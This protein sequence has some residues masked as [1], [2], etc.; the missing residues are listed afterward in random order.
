MEDNLDKIVFENVE[1][2]ESFQDI[3]HENNSNINSVRSD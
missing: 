1:Q 3:I 2:F